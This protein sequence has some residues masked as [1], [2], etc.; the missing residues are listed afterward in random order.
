MSEK[1]PIKD[2]LFVEGR[3]G[4]KLIGNKCK[5]CGQIFFPKAETICLNC[6]HEELEDIQLGPKGKLYSYTTS[7]VPAQ[8]YKPPYMIG[9]VILNGN[10]RVFSQLM[11]IKD[12]PFEV[13]M[14]MELVIDKLWEE[15]G[16]E[17]IGYKFKPV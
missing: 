1:V 4:W 14:E 9:Y 12:K 3:D 15:D 6:C 11:E 5:S 17:V 10:V 8:H 7:Y 2:G 13:D 16:K